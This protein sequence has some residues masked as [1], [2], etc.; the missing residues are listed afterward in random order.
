[1][2]VNDVVIDFLKNELKSENITIDV[3]DDIIHKIVEQCTGTNEDFLTGDEGIEYLN[4]RIYDFELIH[5]GK[6]IDRNGNI[7]TS[8]S[9]YILWDYFG[10]ELIDPLKEFYKNKLSLYAKDY[11]LIK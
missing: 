4:P 11:G 5:D 9:V 2:I 8:D 1:M 10:S 7:N 6:W 3:T